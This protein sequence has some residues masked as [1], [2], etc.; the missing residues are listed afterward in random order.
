MLPNTP[1]VAAA[2]K[3]AESYDCEL[4]HMEQVAR[5]A[6]ML[7]TGLAPLHGYRA[8]ELDLLLAAAL[9]HDVGISNGYARHHKKSRKL[10]LAGELPAFTAREKEVVANIARYHRK[11]S[12]S[13]KHRQFRMFSADEQELVTRLAAI[14]RIADGLDRAHEN[15]VAKVRPQ[16]T[17]VTLWRLNLF[18]PGDLSFAAWA[19]RRKVGLFEKAYNVRVLFEPK[20]PVND[21]DV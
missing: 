21:A 15:A 20:G 4:V 6:A 7:F 11:A 18:G 2:R 12:P 14:L 1:K 8:H 5:L 19:G 13:E 10:I 9:L 3:L 17:S 16:R